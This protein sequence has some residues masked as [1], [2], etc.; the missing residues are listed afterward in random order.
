MNEA[1]R[2]SRRAKRKAF[3]EIL[4]DVGVLA[5]DD[6]RERLCD[7]VKETLYEVFSLAEGPFPFHEGDLGEN[8][9][10]VRQ[11]TESRQP[12]GQRIT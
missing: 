9:P 11:T 3:G 2:R 12:L 1:V 6:D 4:N 8:G 7:R 5:L 10:G